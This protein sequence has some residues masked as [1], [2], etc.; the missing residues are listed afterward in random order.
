MDAVSPEYALIS[1]GLGNKHDHPI[2]SVMDR[3]KE[4]KI[5]VYRTDESGTVV[6]TITNDNIEFSTTPGDYLSGVALAEKEGVE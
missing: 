5:D 6:V 1:A 4:R 3:L 2:E